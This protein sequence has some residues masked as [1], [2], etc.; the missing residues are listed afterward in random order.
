MRPLTS[1]AALHRHRAGMAA[2][3]FALTAPVLILLFLGTFQ[4]TDAVGAKRKLGIATRAIADL[5][6]QY[7]SINAS[8]ADSILQ[9]SNQ[10]MAPYNAA[11]GTFVVSQIYVSPAGAATVQWSRA[12]N[13]TARTTGASVTLPTGV[14]QNDS[15]VILAESSYPY[16]PTVGLAIVPTIAMNEQIYM[17]PRLSDSVNLQ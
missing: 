15:Y 13:G 9:S 16:T 2:V 11:P 5:T 7:T 10:I 1:I 14:A 12:R 8:E 6:T 3:E 17:Y 4:V